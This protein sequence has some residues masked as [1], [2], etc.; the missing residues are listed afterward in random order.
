MRRRPGRSDRDLSTVLLIRDAVMSPRL[1]IH[2]AGIG[3]VKV[4]IS[5]LPPSDSIEQFLR[6]ALSFLSVPPHLHLP[7]ALC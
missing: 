1:K 2:L 3:D 7:S 6:V 4:E 5:R